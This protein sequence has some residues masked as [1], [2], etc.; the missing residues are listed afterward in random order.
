NRLR[1]IHRR[2]PRTRPRA[3]L[4]RQGIGTNGDKIMQDRRA[5]IDRRSFLRGGAAAALAL[6][7]PTSWPRRATGNDAPSERIRLAM[8]GVGTRG[9]GVMRSFA[10]QPDAQ[11]VAV[12]DPFRSR[13]EAA[14]QFLEAHQ[15]PGSVSVHADYRDVMARDDIDAIVCC[16]CD[17]WHIPL[18]YHAA[19][20]RKDMYVEKPLGP[21]LAWAKKLREAVARNERVFQYGTQ[22]RSGSQ[23]R[24]AVELVRNGYLG[25]IERVD[26]WCIDGRRAAEWLDP[27]SRIPE[28]QPKDL[29]YD[30]WLGP[31]PEAPY[32]HYRVQREGSFHTYDYSIGF[33]GGWGAHPLDIAQWGLRTDDTSPIRYEGRGR[34]PPSGGLFTTVLAWDVRATYRSG[35]ELHFMTDEV[36]QPSVKKYRKRWCDHGTTFFGSEGWISVD[37]HGLEASEPRLLSIEL[38]DRDERPP[39]RKGHDQ[40]LERKCVVS[41]N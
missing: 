17:H 8:F 21:S 40:N 27:R 7:A 19:E 18:A 3:A 23:F 29:E 36:A 26:A 37:R 1:G 38:T 12:C 24:Y 41:G 5:R 33:L 28:P 2:D 35:V 32:N 4:S 31:A 20:S 6:S 9:S 25:E 22:Q 34:V 14:R 10:A 16:S 15:G 39:R 13:R 11:F 30:T